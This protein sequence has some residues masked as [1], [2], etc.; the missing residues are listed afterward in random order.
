MQR[1][2]ALL[3]D[4]RQLNFTF[5]EVLEVVHARQNALQKSI[6]KEQANVG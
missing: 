2:D 1:A 6:A 3:A 5:E 4:A